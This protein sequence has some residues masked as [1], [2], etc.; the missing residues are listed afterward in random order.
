MFSYIDWLNN[1]KEKLTGLQLDSLDI[2]ESDKD[3]DYIKEIVLDNLYNAWLSY[4]EILDLENFE[5]FKSDAINE[6][7]NGGTT[8][9]DLAS[10]VAEFMADPRD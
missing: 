7:T 9:E 10:I 2:I 5:E 4:H 6:C 1:S 8:K 3:F